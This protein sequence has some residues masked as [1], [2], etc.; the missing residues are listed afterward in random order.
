L[1][2]SGAANFLARGAA[3]GAGVRAEAAGA[4]KR[5]LVS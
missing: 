1:V 4:E 3:A 5:Q 2:R